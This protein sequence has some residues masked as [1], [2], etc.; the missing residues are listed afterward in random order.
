MRDEDDGR[1]EV[2]VDVRRG[3]PWGN[4]RM[5]TGGKPHG[6]TVLSLGWTDVD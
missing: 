5:L 2:C 6:G 4:R 1:E 3:S